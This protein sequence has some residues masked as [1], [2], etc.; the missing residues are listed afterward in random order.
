MK[1]KRK[2]TDGG[3]QPGPEHWGEYQRGTADHAAGAEGAGAGAAHQPGGA[4]GGGAGSALPVSLRMDGSGAI[5]RAGDAALSA[6]SLPVLNAFR[7]FLEAERRRARRQVMAWGVV[8]LLFVVGALAGGYVVARRFMDRVHTD[9]ALAREQNEKVRTEAV[10]K[11]ENVA[12]MAGQLNAGIAE[13]RKVVEQG[14]HELK[15]RITTQSDDLKFLRESLQ[16]LEVENALLQSTVQGLRS[17]PASQPSAGAP[18][19]AEEDDETDVTLPATNAP[20]LP[21][22]RI[23]PPAKE[24]APLEPADDTP[25]LRW[26]LPLGPAPAPPPAA[27][28]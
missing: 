23:R 6:E 22:M 24:S 3:A 16:S 10:A 25:G 5:L 9:L 8:I 7:E 12:Q 26:R 14:Q 20:A 19:P 1:R 2:N 4:P 11:I 17:R 18:A 13:Q 21:P 27:G 15:T 28:S